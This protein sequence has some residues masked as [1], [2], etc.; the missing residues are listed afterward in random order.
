M[1]S[2]TP[3]PPYYAVIFSSLRTK[4][5]DDYAETNAL[6]NQLAL[7]Q[8]GFLGMEDASSDIG[9]SISYWRDLAAIKKWKENL[10]HK[11]AQEKG[12][13]LWYH[14]YKVRIANVEREYEFLKK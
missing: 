5:N 13:Q 6:M 4:N 1:L 11:D 12:R 10:A 7:K 9:I 14:Q 8:D 2:N 3:P